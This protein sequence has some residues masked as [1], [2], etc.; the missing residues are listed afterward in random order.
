MAA[1][2][3]GDLTPDE[4][5]RFRLRKSEVHREEPMLQLPV[6]VGSKLCHASSMQGR[7]RECFLDFGGW[8]L[9][10]GTA[11]VLQPYRMVAHNRLL[12]L[13]N[14][15]EI[16]SAH[17]HKFRSTSTLKIKLS[18]ATPPIL[19]FHVPFLQKYNMP[20][21]VLFRVLGIER[22][23]E[24]M[25]CAFPEGVEAADPGLVHAYLSN[26]R[27]PQRLLTIED[28]VARVL[29]ATQAEVPSNSTPMRYVLGTICNELLPHV[30]QREPDP[31]R[32][33]LA[34][35]LFLAYMARRRLATSMGLEDCD[36]RDFMGNYYIHYCAPILALM[37]R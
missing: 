34:K 12:V 1:E 32:Q 21:V 31:I 37:F 11:K 4:H 17:G 19:S 5:P 25:A 16:R 28:I 14:D 15:A 10:N 3:L 6:M 8:V 35:A 18:K 26:L 24:M 33:R 7:A 2:A 20:L 13:E 9:V 29:A 22:E 30:A 36:D 23:E 27:Q